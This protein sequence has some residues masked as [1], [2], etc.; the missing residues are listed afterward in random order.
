MSFFQFC[1]ATVKFF[2]KNIVF[3]IVVMENLLVLST[4]VESCKLIC[5]RV[6]DRLKTSSSYLYSNEVKSSPSF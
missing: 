6:D 5:G 2:W 3:E 4:C 1:C